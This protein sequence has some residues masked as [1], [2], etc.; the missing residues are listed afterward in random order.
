MEKWQKQE[1]QNHAKSGPSNIHLKKKKN[2][3]K[4]TNPTS[5]KLTYI[6]GKRKKKTKMHSNKNKN[7]QVHI[8]PTQ[9]KTNIH[10]SKNND[11]TMKNQSW[12]FV[13]QGETKRTAVTEP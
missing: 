5:K 3:L 7:V 11:T 8:D 13:V 6:E 1:W 10:W 4:K 9:K 12:Q 2:V